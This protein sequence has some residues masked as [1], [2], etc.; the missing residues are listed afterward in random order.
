MKPRRWLL[1]LLLA[2]FLLASA[3]FIT[4]H[5]FDMEEDFRQRI[6]A[7]LVKAGLEEISLGVLRP[8]WIGLDL[9]DLRFRLP[10]DGTRLQVEQLHFRLS[11]M[12]WIRSGGEALAALKSIDAAGVDLTFNRLPA[13]SGGTGHLPELESLSAQ[14]GLLPEL[15]IERGRI[16]WQPESGTEARTLVDNLDGLAIRHHG[17][18]ELLIRSQLL[19]AREP[20]FRARVMLDT[21]SLNGWFTL[22][23]DS[24]VLSLAAIEPLPGVEELDAHFGLSL[25]GELS[26]AGVSSLEGAGRLLLRQA[27][28]KGL[29]S[30]LGA[31]LPFVLDMAG[32]RS[33]DAMLQVGPS[34][35]QLSAR[36]DWSGQNASARLSGDSLSAA[37][38]ATE[39]G[40]ADAL[41]GRLELVATR[42]SESADTLALRLDW[43]DGAYRTLT[44]G[45]LQV[46]GHLAAG[47]LQASWPDWSLSAA[48]SIAG[49]LSLDLAKQVPELNL[50][51]LLHS[52]FGEVDSSTGVLAGEFGL[53]ATLTP[54]GPSLG[55]NLLQLSCGAGESG[56]L[57]LEGRLDSGRLPESGL[58]GIEGLLLRGDGEIFGHWF[59]DAGE[60]LHWRVE[61]EEQLLTLL[62]A[63]RLDAGEFGSARCQLEL[64]GWGANSFASLQAEHRGRSLSAT[65]ELVWT[66]EQ[67][68]LRS[69]LSLHGW[70]G[71]RLEGAAE[72]NISGDELLIRRIRLDDLELEGSVD[73]GQ[74]TY[75]L[76][77]RSDDQELE[78]VWN[79]LIE[80]PPP[81]GLGR[82]SL[83]AGGEGSLDNPGLRGGLEYRTLRGERRLRLRSELELSRE[84]LRLLQATVGLAGRPLA[85]LSLDWTLDP[86][87]RMLDAQLLRSELAWLLPAEDSLQQAPVKGWLAGSGHFRWDGQSRM[88]GEGWVLA[89]SVSILGNPF[90]GLQGRFRKAAGSESFQL[91]SLRLWRSK[92]RE[93]VLVLDGLF[94]PDPAGALDLD[95]SLE[96]DLLHPL[97]VRADG[98][99]ST[100]FRKA[101]GMGSVRLNLGGS[102]EEP[103]IRSGNI[104]LKDAELDLQ[105]VFR[106]VRKL[107][108]EMQVRDGQLQI[109]DFVADIE[110]NRLRISNIH[111]PPASAPGLEPLI[112]SLPEL[113]LGILTL[114]THDRKGRRGPVE[115]NIPG[116]MEAAWEGHISLLGREAG[117]VFMVAGPVE[118]P[119]VRGLV[120]VRNARFT[121][122]FIKG[123]RPR[124]NL[125]QGVIDVLE[126]MEWDMA[127][128]AERNVNYYRKVQG[129]E[130]SPLFENFQGFLDRITVDIWVEPGSKALEF[131]GRIS[132]ESF[133]VVGEVDSR[134]G[135]I[136]FLDKDF[137]V[138][139]AGLLFDRTSVLPVVW[140]RAVHTLVSS[141]L[142]AESTQGLFNPDARQIY[143]QVYSE[144]DLGNH[145]PRGR[146]DEIRLELVDDLNASENLLLAAQEDLLVE[147]GLDPYD[148]RASFENMLPGVVAGLWELPLQPIESRLRRELRL[149]V[150]RIFVPVLRNTLEELVFTESRQE[151]V[152]QSYLSYLQ[153]SRV[154]LGKSLGPRY[155]ASW[156]GQ[157]MSAT[158]AEGTAAVHLFQRYNLEYE[159]SRNLKLTG[160]LVFDPLREASSFRGDPRL[161]LRYRLNY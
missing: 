90:D 2:P 92:P 52:S 84:A 136:L 152:S 34:V 146:W 65:G 3:L 1:A 24:L 140:G 79:L 139:D 81:D 89:D 14:L 69:S 132:D 125:L 53:E 145:V 77:L 128:E 160:E 126:S 31:R 137:E 16:S 37:V 83:L 157:L 33:E 134:R 118:E 19:D 26:Q 102:L 88:F 82:L 48:T 109:Q 29:T 154:V 66:P 78:Q 55:E 135:S 110:R 63:F 62:E 57:R 72:L 99:S 75:S 123:T 147:L 64:E 71:S 130:D 161:L 141:G 91:D 107:N 116:L 103:R 149:D 151:Q 94:S 159:V 86:A 124:T 119:L 45:A 121:F 153:G 39:L 22:D 25:R 18:L 7:Q 115:T 76:E 35:I 41:G 158:P 138:E 96:G 47:R 108:L 23:L 74:R 59:M 87:R 73:L 150:V 27:R 144:D 13:S 106:K 11:P 133:R 42:R 131:S 12:L 58:P 143:I 70:R 155:F 120:R 148:A 56:P 80:D 50:H 10:G 111:V 142:E 40:L 9:S 8:A 54:E 98:R 51:A 114:E 93:L 104:Q 21:D 46:D 156:T 129:F 38:L 20:A 15:S 43:L 60:S 105:S 95:I 4:W 112:L 101:R 32:L 97:T 68:E 17:Q 85:E 28:L 67:A 61:A 6:E 100:F 122:P 49:E 117:E 113:D 30:A 36:S 44:P 127:L 5:L